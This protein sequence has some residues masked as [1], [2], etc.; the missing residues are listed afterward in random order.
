MAGLLTPSH[1]ARPPMPF[2]SWSNRAGEIQAVCPAGYTCNDNVVSENMTQRILSRNNTGETYVQVMIEDNNPRTGQHRSETFVNAS[3][4]QNTPIPFTEIGEIMPVDPNPGTDAVETTQLRAFN[5]GVATQYSMSQTVGTTN[6]TYSFSLNTGYF[7]N[8]GEPAVQINHDVTDTAF[9]IG[10]DYSFTYTQRRNGQGG[11]T[12]WLYGIDQ[13]VTNSAV[14]GAGNGG[15]RDDQNFVL[16][17]A[18]GDYITAGSATL[19]PSAGGGMGGMGGGA[20]GANPAGGGESPPANAVVPTPQPTPFPQPPGAP[21][22]NPAMGG[23]GGGVPPGGSVAW[24]AGSEVQVIWIGQVCP[25]CMIGM[26]GMGAMGG[27][28]SFSFQQYENISTAQA[29]ATRTIAGAAPFTWTNPPFGPQPP[30]L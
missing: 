27:T 4:E 14:I 24:G 7:N 11:I 18:S 13:F 22:G 6:M 19:P 23:G 2:D 17:R 10:F 29:A 15:T 26:G 8:V 25:G 1:A 9:G 28:G 3:N 12:G 16:R 5:T 20:P 21:T 30:G